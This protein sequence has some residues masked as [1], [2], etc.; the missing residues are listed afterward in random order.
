MFWMANVPDNNSEVYDVGTEGSPW[1]EDVLKQ[2]PYYLC[3]TVATSQNFFLEPGH[4][5]TNFDKV[6]AIS[7][8]I[9]TNRN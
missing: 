7:D 3:V 8:K 1:T 9:G 2:I 5:E 6:A 4:P